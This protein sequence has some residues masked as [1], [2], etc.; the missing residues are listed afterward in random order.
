[1][2]VA[3]KSPVNAN[4]ASSSLA[5]LVSLESSDSI[6]VLAFVVSPQVG[7]YTLAVYRARSALSANILIMISL[8]AV[9]A[10]LE[11]MIFIPLV[12]DL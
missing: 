3:L 4:L 2:V 6:A 11:V 12:T 5:V 10:D 7:K 8:P 9:S 1:M